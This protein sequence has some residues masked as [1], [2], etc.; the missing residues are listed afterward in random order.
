MYMV[1]VSSWT[2]LEKPVIG[3]YT[4]SLFENSFSEGINF[5][6][7][8]YNPDFMTHLTMTLIVLNSYPENVFSI[9]I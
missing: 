6:G 8:S 7:L 2:H 3:V 1:T 9:Y 5:S 4:F